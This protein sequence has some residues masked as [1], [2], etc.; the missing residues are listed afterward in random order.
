MLPSSLRM[1]VDNRAPAGPKPP[2]I[3]NLELSS[4]TPAGSCR[5]TDIDPRSVHSIESGEY[6][7]QRSVLSRDDEKPPHTTR[8]LPMRADVAPTVATG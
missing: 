8:L 2:V 1:S 4:M 6:S 3:Q 7:E 5:D